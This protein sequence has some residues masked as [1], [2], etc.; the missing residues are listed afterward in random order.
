MVDSG[1]DLGDGRAGE[2]VLC[3]LD[4]RTKGVGVGDGQVGQ[5]LAIDFDA[6][7]VQPIDQPAVAHAVQP[8]RRVD[9][10]DPQL[11]K[12]TLAGPT[13]PV[14]VLHRMHELLVGRTVRPTLVSVVS[15]RLLQNGA[16]VLAP[17][18]GSLD[19]GHWGCSSLLVPL[20]V[21]RIRFGQK[22]RSRLGQLRFGQFSQ[23]LQPIRCRASFAPLARP[24]W[25]SRSHDPDGGYE[26][27]SSF[28]R[29]ATG[30]PYADVGGRSR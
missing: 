25:R 28:L 7:Q 13:V 3:G 15:L 6:G 19:S 12:V 21:S 14:G 20:V 29:G 4:Q 22:L 2:R 16:V 10:L 27:W 5:H 11:A 18:N 26:R 8:S 9:A 30:M 17:M 24:P 23:A 1:S